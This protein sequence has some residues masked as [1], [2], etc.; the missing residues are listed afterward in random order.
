MTIKKAELHTHLE[1][2]IMPDLAIK[3]A[4]RNKLALP[5]TLIAKD[6][7]SYTYTDFLD[8]LKAYDSV[9]AVI[10]QPDDYYDITFEY[11]KARAKEDAIYVEM[12]YSPDHAEMSSDIPSAE[13]LQAI[14]QAIMDAEEK[15]NIIGRI[16]V[17]A[18]RHFGVEAAVKVATQA[19]KEKVSCIVGFG[20][21]GDEINFPPGLFVEAYQIAADGGLGCTVHAG[22]FSPASGMLEAMHHLPIQRIGHGVQ[23]FN[24][25]ETIAQ[26]K[27][28][29]I[30]LEVCPSSNV[31][32]G[33][34]KDLLHHPLPQLVAADITISLGSDDPPFFR[35]SLAK[36]YQR[37]QESYQ[38][39]NDQ[40]KQFTAMAIE[41]SFANEE[42]KIKL[43][44]HL[45]D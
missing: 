32:L 42:T 31:A 12:M 19:L 17:T 5:E 23:A 7:E 8:F 36:E 26:L 9:A 28:R 6:G 14:Q 1:G 25:P 34:F 24:S 27:D 21:G 13:H 18:V 10:K 45:E 11:L 16:I 35:T 44:K 43:K 33:L 15:Y 38:Y 22:E 37:V 40:M 20:L 3:L 4:K 2:T 39:T 41:S 30:A 29:N